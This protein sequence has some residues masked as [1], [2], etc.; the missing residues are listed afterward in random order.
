MLRC[1]GMLCILAGSTG[2]GMSMA[3]ELELRTQELAVLQHLMLALR[4]EIR[5]MHQPLS[6][7]FVCLAEKAP[8]PFEAFFSCMADELKMRCGNTAEEIWRRNLK[9][10]LPNLHISSQ[11][12]AEFE[13]L[14]S[15]LGYL[16]VKMQIDT[17]DHYLEQL[18]ISSVQ[19]MEAAKS[20]RRL[21]QYMGA[22]GGAALVV[23]I[24]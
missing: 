13:K 17:L 19:A 14:G 15:M 11:E 5:Y 9:K 7:A 1:L 20:R 3:R 8:A 22:L 6:E 4:G 16:D 12:Y 18:K 10:C 21:Y 24:F 23:L 2:I